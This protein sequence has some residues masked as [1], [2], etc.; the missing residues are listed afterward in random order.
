MPQVPVVHFNEINLFPRPGLTL[1]VTGLAVDRPENGGALRLTVNSTP[2]A[3]F[4]EEIDLALS[5][6]AAKQLAE[7][8]EQ[9]VEEYLH[10]Q[11]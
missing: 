7:L 3:R 6:P 2:L 9:A 8:L 1:Q 4:V 10:S 11:P 5:P